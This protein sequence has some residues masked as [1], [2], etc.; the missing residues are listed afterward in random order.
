MKGHR[1]Y[2]SNFRN[3]AAIVGPLA[4]VSISRGKPRWLKGGWLCHCQPGTHGRNYDAL[5][6]TAAAL[7]GSAEEYDRA[8]AQ[9]LAGL[10]PRAVYDDLGENAV[11]LCFCQPNVFCHRRIVAEWF[12][13]HLGVI[14]PELGLARDD[15]YVITGNN[16]PHYVEPSAKL[17]RIESQLAMDGPS[18]HAPEAPPAPVTRTRRQTAHRQRWDAKAHRWK[19]AK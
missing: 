11:L 13:F 16:Y 19:A 7:K 2:T 12:E 14:V 5:A 8:F 3:L 15:T 1:V 4:P 9:I 17:A 10:D 18:I 6:P